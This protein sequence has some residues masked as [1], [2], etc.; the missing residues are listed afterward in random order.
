MHH[1]TVPMTPEALPQQRLTAVRD[2]PPRPEGLVFQHEGR[3]RPKALQRASFPRNATFLGQVEWA[4]SPMH[5]AIH[6]HYL[7]TRRDYW[8]IWVR[9]FDDGDCPWGWRWWFQG[10][11]RRIHGV[12]E[13]TAAVHLL[14]DL[15]REQRDDMG[16][17]HFHWINEEGE[18]DA[19]DLAAIGRLAWPGE[20]SHD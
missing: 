11:A 20:A 8:I 9:W 18:F 3:P 12:D 16:Y 4:W 14:A 7:A 2:L 1:P 5:N 10:W 13:R 15:W 17:D 19:A 6:S